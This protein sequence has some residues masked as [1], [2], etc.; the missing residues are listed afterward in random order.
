MALGHNPNLMGGK[1][2]AHPSE[3]MGFWGATPIVQPTGTPAAAIDLATALTLVNFL[4][5]KL[6]AVGI[7]A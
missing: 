1:V 3:K 4:R 5:T 6:L 2:A 7:V